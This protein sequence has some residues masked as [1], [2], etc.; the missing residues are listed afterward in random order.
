MSKGNSLAE[1]GSPRAL[2]AEGKSRKR[3]PGALA[4][5]SAGSNQGLSALPV[6]PLLIGAGIGVA[7]LGAALAVTS[8]RR[9]ASPLNAANPALTKA[10]LVAVARVVS[11]HTVRSVAASALL[12][13]AEAVKR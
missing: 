9:S 8:R 3:A 4:R 13:V 5:R 7:L 12:D 10:A 11:G 6:T 2:P 1:V